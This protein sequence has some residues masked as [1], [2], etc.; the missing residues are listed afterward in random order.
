MPR[1][2]FNLR[3]AH[4]QLLDRNG[5]SCAS[6]GEAIEYGVVAVLDLIAEEGRFRNWTTWA[7]EIEDENRLHVV[8]LP[9]SL[10]LKADGRRKD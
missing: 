7:L 6:L 5:E 1:Y 4:L 10:V 9:F 2:Y 8:T 3:R